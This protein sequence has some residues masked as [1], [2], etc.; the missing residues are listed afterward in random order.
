MHCVLV[1]EN[2]LLDGQVSLV[3]DPRVSEGNL[4][5][6]GIEGVG[7]GPLDLFHTVTARRV[8]H[9]ADMVET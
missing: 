8:G 1:H 5:D 7:K 4:V 3:N 9:N 6:L 2:L